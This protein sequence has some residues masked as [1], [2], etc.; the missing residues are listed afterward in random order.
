MTCPGLFEKVQS[1]KS[2]VKASWFRTFQYS[3]GKAIGLFTWHSVRWVLNWDQPTTE[4][5]AHLW[6]YPHALAWSHLQL[7][8][9]RR[10]K[11]PTDFRYGVCSAFWALLLPGKLHTEISHNLTRLR[12]KWRWQQACPLFSPR[13]MSSR[14]SLLDSGQLANYNEKSQ[15]KIR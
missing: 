13:P 5:T 4:L 15:Q 9:C 6:H 3:R 7:L 10:G 8:M 2:C 12:I 11:H 1:Q 14:E